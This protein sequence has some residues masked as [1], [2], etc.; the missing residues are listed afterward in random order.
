MLGQFWV[1][2]Y[3]LFCVKM[4]GMSLFWKFYFRLT[5]QE[6]FN[7]WFHKIS[8]SMKMIVVLKTRSISVMN[9]HDARLFW[10][11]II[12]FFVCMFN[13]EFQTTTV[14]ITLNGQW[15]LPFRSHQSDHHHSWTSQCWKLSI[16]G[17][18]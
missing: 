11:F 7:I 15:W 16:Y 9:D 5:S 4:F 2:F 12:N 13:V 3:Q 14:F 8:A 18:T 17:S 10:Y 6:I 1:N